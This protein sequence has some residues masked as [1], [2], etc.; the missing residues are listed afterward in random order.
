MKEN[1]DPKPRTKATPKPLISEK[2][3]AEANPEKADPLK[4]LAASELG[5]IVSYLTELTF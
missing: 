4:R 5:L 2:K 1:P 3:P